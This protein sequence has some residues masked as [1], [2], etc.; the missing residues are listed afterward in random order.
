MTPLQQLVLDRMAELDLSFREA[1]AKS[2]G[3]ISA[4]ALNNIATGN[5]TPK[6]YSDKSLEGIALALDVRLSVVRKA[7]GETEKTPT[8][9][10]LPKKA[11]RLTAKQRQAVLA[12]V[13]A[14]L[15][16]ETRP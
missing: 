11:Q 14:L 3:K 13:N 15:D 16:E 8:E 5:K 7:A 6:H 4:A 12:M 10:R 1:A 9:F 2:S